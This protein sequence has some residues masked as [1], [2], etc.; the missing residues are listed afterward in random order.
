MQID[1]AEMN[2]DSTSRKEKKDKQDNPQL[3]GIDREEPVAF[4]D[5]SRA[6]PQS[7]ECDAKE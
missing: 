4:K 7:K 3:N 1:T 2:H 6:K 5:S